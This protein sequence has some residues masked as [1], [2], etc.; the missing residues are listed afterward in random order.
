MENVPHL[1]ESEKY[2]TWKKLYAFQINLSDKRRHIVI[3]KT[4]K[5]LLS[6]VDS[7]YVFDHIT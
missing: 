4:C 6:L 5:S 1:D 7:L 3:Q 2:S